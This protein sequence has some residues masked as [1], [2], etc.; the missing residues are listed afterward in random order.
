MKF[1]TA[2]LALLAGVASAQA[3]DIRGSSKDTPAHVLPSEPASTAFSGA[4]A[5]V[6]ISWQSFD[7][8]H[9]GSLA[10]GM[11]GMGDYETIAAG[12][13]PDLSEQSFR[14]GAQAGYNW[15][16]GRLYFG[17]RFAVDFGEVEASMSR[18][19]TLIDNGEGGTWKHHGKLSVS[20]DFLAT[21]SLKLGIA[22]TEN[23]G[24]YGIGG[25]SMSDI[26]VN[27]SGKHIISDGEESVS[28]L[29]WQAA[30]SETKIGWHIGAGAEFDLGFWNAFAEYTYHDL[31]E[32]ES[33]GTV[34]GGLIA[35]DHKADVTMNVVKIGVNRR[36]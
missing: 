34:Y 26:D 20:S 31:G 35:Y 3:A 36:F 23:V 8:E 10:A 18:V 2:I 25:I 7:V 32:V 17:P 16:V 30:N 11:F 21:A 27:A 5:G 28:F 1:L 24:V 6:S 15:R 9:R 13:L 19:D 29:P 12:K 33:R 14:I 4:Y 22:V